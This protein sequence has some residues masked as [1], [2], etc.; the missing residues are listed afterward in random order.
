MKLQDKLESLVSMLKAR[1]LGKRIPLAVRL[2][3]TNRCTLQCKYC[4]LWNSEKS[5]LGTGDILRLI[6]ELASLG[7]KRISISGGEPLLRADIAEIIDCCWKNGIYPEMNSNGSVVP[8]K[9]GV[10]KKIDFL[11]LSLDGPEEIHDYVRGAG[12]YR[13]VIEA[14]EAAF[15]NKVNFG[16]ACTLTRFNVNS[17]DHILALSEKY[18]AIAAFQPLK[19]IYRGIKD[20]TD[21]APSP[22]EFRS[23]IASLIVKKKSG[24]RYIRNSLAGLKHI[25]SWPHYA[26]LKCWAGRIFCIIDTDGTLYPCDRIDYHMEL[27]NCISLGI[28]NALSLLPYVRCGGCGFCGALELNY[29]MQLKLNG[30]PSIRKI[31]NFRKR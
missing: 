4:N 23:A 20:I 28:G 14:A 3:V 13:R 11:K 5:E 6:K 26:K 29:L 7:T 15:K 22:E 10:V 12:S 18:G 16:F 19:Q 30:M 31:I 9:I 24:N 1:F 2:Q 25:C 21:I 17:L 27:P 8:E